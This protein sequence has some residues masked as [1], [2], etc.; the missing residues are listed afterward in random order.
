MRSVCL[1]VC[2]GL[3]LVVVSVWGWGIH[4]PPPRAWTGML[5]EAARVYH[6]YVCEGCGYT[7]LCLPTI[8]AE[9]AIALPVTLS[10]GVLFA[11]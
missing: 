3:S 2:G 7:L 1:F 6:A 4:V 11:S 9:G 5:G 10:G 8:L